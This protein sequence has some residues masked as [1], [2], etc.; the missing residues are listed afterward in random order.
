MPLRHRSVLDKV[1][2]EVDTVLRTLIVPQ[3]RT[4]LRNP[5]LDIVDEPMTIDEKKHVTGLMRINHAGE[6]CAQA[7][8]QGQSL[9]AKLPKV[10]EK[11]VQAAYEEVEHLSW[12]EMRLRELGSEPSKLNPLWYGGSLFI[13]LF[14]GLIS[15]RVSLGFVAETESQ[16]TAHLISHL[17]QLPKQ[18]KRSWAIL[19][20]MQTDEAKHEQEARDA[21]A[22]EFPVFVKGLMQA[23]SKIMTK[24]AYF[25]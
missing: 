19:A 7:L 3:S 23:V 17:K 13:G 11:M 6:V 15:D 25:I 18:D 4:S 12:C 10:R 16:V 8:Y 1:I 20:Q 5:A 14:A 24:T 2:G 21:G 9:T 22:M